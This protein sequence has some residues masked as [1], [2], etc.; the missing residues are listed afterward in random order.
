MDWMEVKS[1]AISYSKTNRIVSVY[2]DVA[3][4]GQVYFYIGESTS[5]CMVINID[6]SCINFRSRI[7]GSE[8]R[9]WTIPI[10][11]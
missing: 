10:S 4:K 6:P 11:N 3:R 7:N 8:E 1:F 9:M 2:A 5:N